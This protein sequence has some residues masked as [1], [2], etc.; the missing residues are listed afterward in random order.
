MSATRKPPVRFVDSWAS[1]HFDTLRGVAA[2]LVLLEHCRN[3]FFL[4]Y[5]DLVKPG[6]W[7]LVPYGLSGSGHQ[8]VILFFVL[9]GFF[10]GGTVFR[11]L[12][13]EQW[14]WS[15]YLLRRFIRLW[16]VLL[17]TLLL[18]LLWDRTGLRMHHAPLLYAGRV[19]DHMLGDTAALLAPH[20]FFGNLFFVQGIV[21][22]VFGT[23]GALWSL[24]FEFWY[25]LLFP[26]GLL[27]VWPR[28]PWR[29][30]ALY[31]V[32]FAGIAW[33][34]RGAILPSF[35]IWLAGAALFKLRAPSCTGGVGRWVRLLATAIYFPVFFGLSRYHGI[36]G[37]LSDYLLTGL[38][39]GY[40]WLLL[41]ATERFRPEA[42]PVKGSRE[43]ARLSYTLYAAHTPML[44][45]LA[46][47]LIGDGRWYPTA[48]T[49]L[50]GVG[51]MVAALLYSYALAWL[52]E[53]RTDAVRLRLEHLFGMRA[54]APV[55]PSNPL[56]DTPV[57]AAA[58]AS[59]QEA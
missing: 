58:A 42:L 59:I 39:L 34:V 6:R 20:I 5:P 45:L 36:N 2:L 47:F 46:S 16:I 7:M 18:C 48:R 43:L 44:V 27:A 21:T 3:L 51:L 9:S 11:S 41:S 55:L 1:V 31:G 25:Y 50:F 54:V 19:P 15:G 23:D 30:R 37:L 56:A 35:P 29:M 33:F 52:T 8:S 26:L 32:I 28:V 22:P 12:E 4:D 13:R 24:A 10:I 57:Q 53:F 49:L 14:E 40:L 38:T 17:P